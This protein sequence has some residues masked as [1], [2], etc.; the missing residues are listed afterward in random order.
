MAAT[1]CTGPSAR[2][3]EEEATAAAPDS[4]TTTA[5]LRYVIIPDPLGVRVRDWG[6]T[7]A[8]VLIGDFRVRI[9]VFS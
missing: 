1:N 6:F 4:V 9:W 8:R 5:D 3:A 2:A 7:V